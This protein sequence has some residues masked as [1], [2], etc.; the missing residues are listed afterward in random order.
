MTPETHPR[1]PRH[2]AAPWL[3]FNIGDEVAKLRQEPEWRAANHNAITL[4]KD[5][6]MGLILMAL[7]KGS[8]LDEHRAPA[9][10]AVHVL[11]G[12]IA[13]RIGEEKLTLGTGEIVTMEQAAKHEVVAMEESTILLTI[14]G[15][16]DAA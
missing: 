12:Q 6:G 4:L 13:L 3:R 7:G 9:T 15:R 14:G 8:R 1:P 2:L 16:R 5:P 11:A 10:I